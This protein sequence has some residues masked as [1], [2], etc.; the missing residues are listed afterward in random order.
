MSFLI[1]SLQIPYFEYLSI[2]RGGMW[3]LWF[4]Q[5]YDTI[6]KIQIR[7]ANNV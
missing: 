5:R 1:Y 7:G 3:G 6:S 2:L 4:V